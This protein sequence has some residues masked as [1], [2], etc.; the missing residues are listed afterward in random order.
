[1]HGFCLGS[2]SRAAATAAAATAVVVDNTPHKH[3]PATH[4]QTEGAGDGRVGVPRLRGHFHL[5]R[6]LYVRLICVWDATRAADCGWSICWLILM[7]Y[8]ILCV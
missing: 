2:N 1:M 8:L 7:G 6:Q 4:A 3:T 5:R